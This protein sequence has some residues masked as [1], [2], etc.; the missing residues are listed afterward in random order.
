[1]KTNQLTSTDV[2]MILTYYL[3]SIMLMHA[4]LIVLTA[5]VDLV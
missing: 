1:M 5:I 4:K 2:A 3:F